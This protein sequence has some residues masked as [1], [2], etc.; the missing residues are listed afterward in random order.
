MNTMIDY[1][2][3]R[4]LS[5]WLRL[6]AIV[7]CCVTVMATDVRAESAVAVPPSTQSTSNGISL[8]GKAPTAQS[9]WKR[10]AARGLRFGGRALKSSV[11]IS[12]IAP[13]IGALVASKAGKG[14]WGALSGAAVAGIAEL[15]SRRINQ[16][17]T[18]EKTLATQADLSTEARARLTEEL[19]DRRLLQKIWPLIVLISTSGSALATRAKAPEADV[20]VVPVAASIA[21]KKAAAS[22]ASQVA[23]ASSLHEDGG[24]LADYDAEIVFDEDDIAAW[25]K[26]RQGV[27]WD[28][29]RKSTRQEREF[30]EAFDDP[31]SNQ[32]YCLDAEDT[33]DVDNQELLKQLEALRRENADICGSDS[34]PA[35]SDSNGDTDREALLKRIEAQKLEAA[36]ILNAPAGADDD[37]FAELAAL[38]NWAAQMKAAEQLQVDTPEIS[39]VPGNDSAPANTEALV[40][41]PQVY[42]PEISTVPEISAVSGSDSAPVAQTDTQVHSPLRAPSEGSASISTSANSPFKRVSVREELEALAAQLEEGEDIIIPPTQVALM[43]EQAERDQRELR[44][45]EE[46]AQR[47]LRY[48]NDSFDGGPL[49]M[50]E[51]A[52]DRLSSDGVGGQSYQ[53]EMSS[54]VSG[55][56][57]VGSPA[58]PR[59]ALSPSSSLPPHPKLF[60]MDDAEDDAAQDDYGQQSMFSPDTRKRLALD[61]RTR[62]RAQESL[63]KLEEARATAPFK[64]VVFDSKAPAAIRDE[65]GGSL[66]GNVLRLTVQNNALVNAALRRQ[67][68]A[69]RDQEDAKRRAGRRKFRSQHD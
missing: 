14:P 10:L 6:S 16:I 58:T 67:W 63:R 60:T 38:T 20:E 64:K 27:T 59:G 12:A 51:L 36:A 49:A 32:L 28:E 56:L 23:E 39:A 5:N 31:E 53:D 37:L 43:I 3:E 7:L 13:I 24:A 34:A 62:A 19:A 54:S 52:G 47:E 66:P 17:G 40:E 21:T 50:S 61:A 35:A 45:Q 46:R 26:V 41:Q 29:Y 15:V 57:S 25:E 55:V 18:L 42:T 68:Q 65:K 9:G 22:E 69:E 8:A 48:K 4:V 11:G 44:Y 1:V 33:D 30:E 2:Q